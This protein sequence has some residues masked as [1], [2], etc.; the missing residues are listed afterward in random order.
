G[1]KRGNPIGL[2]VRTARE[3]AGDSSQTFGTNTNGE[4]TGVL[5][6]DIRDPLSTLP[7][8]ASNTAGCFQSGGVIGR[9]PAD[10]LYPLGLAIL[11]RYPLPNK[12]QE[13]NTTFN[14]QM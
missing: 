5:I 12:I 3:R 10:R 13:I 9:I 2:R 7:C 11:N 6:P 8:N 14:Y 1:I 4:S